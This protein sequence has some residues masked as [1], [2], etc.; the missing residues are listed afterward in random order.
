MIKIQLCPE[1]EL[2]NKYWW[3]PDLAV[4]VLVGVLS[5]FGANLFLQSMRDETATKEAIRDTWVAQ[6][7]QIRPMLEKFKKLD[8]EV[9]ILNTKISALSKITVSK[10]D[11]VL[12]IVVF[13]QIQTLTPPGVWLHSVQLSGNRAMTLKG[14]SKEGLLIGE[15]LMGFRETMNP[16]TL[17]SD[18]RT[19]VGFANVSF[20]E[21]KAEDADQHFKDIEDVLNFD[22]KAT[23]SEK[24]A[25][26]PAID[27]ND[28]LNLPPPPTEPMKSAVPV[29]AQGKI[30]S[31]KSGRL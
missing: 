16:Q 17:T 21:I 10:L 4:L 13:E 15:Y 1:I 31:V 22:V 30:T 18:I 6:S 8:Q 25:A 28:T 19:K 7:A 12:P 20:S 5:Y 23:V 9:A 2:E 24:Q 29:Q 3:A 14:S 11:K 27:P 26:T